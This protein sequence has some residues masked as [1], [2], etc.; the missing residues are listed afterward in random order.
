MLSKLSRFVARSKLVAGKVI[1]ACLKFRSIRLIMLNLPPAIEHVSALNSLDGLVD[2]CLDVGA[3]RGQFSLVAIAEIS[4][5]KKLVIVE[6]LTGSLEAFSRFLS[7]FKPQLPVEIVPAVASSAPGSLDFFVSQKDCC[8]SLLPPTKTGI[9]IHRQL[10]TVDTIRVDSIKLSQLLAEL[11]AGP[12]Q[13][14]RILLKL[15]IQGAELDALKGCEDALTT[16]VSYVYVEVSDIEHYSGQPC[17]NSVASYLAMKGFGL[18]SSY[19]EHYVDGEL[20][21][22]DYLFVNSAI[23][24]LGGPYEG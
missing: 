22:A 19:N 6:P 23:V 4:S 12:D 10:N 7:A 9:M 13:G 15:D 14:L 18:V 2:C 8:S 20:S 1:Y 3:N 24:G 17:S 16:N 21:Y 11:N 5:L